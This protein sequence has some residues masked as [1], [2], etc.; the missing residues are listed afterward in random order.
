MEEKA[1]VKRRIGVMFRL[2][3][4]IAGLYA[5]PFRRTMFDKC[6]PAA[7][8]GALALSVPLYIERV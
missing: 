7:K 6:G 5:T 4:H 1:E 2:S 3:S 8:M